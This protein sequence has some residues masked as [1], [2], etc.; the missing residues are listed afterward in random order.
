MRKVLL[1]WVLVLVFSGPGLADDLP[2][3]V[4]KSC[5]KENDVWLFSGSVH[6]ISILNIGVPLA[7][8]NALSNLASS[9]GISVNAAVGHKIDGS[10]TD[11]Y[12]EVINVSQGYI[13]DRVV[14]YGVRQKELHV[15]QYTDSSTGRQK[16]NVHA[17]LE[18]ADA[19]LKKAQADFCRRAVA[20][21]TPIMK[22]KGEADQKDAG[23]IRGLLRK[24]GL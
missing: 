4:H 6:G 7:R 13:L 23:I 20:K 3:W 16:F 10:E 24:V 1:A 14:A 9:I 11:G 12:T 17:L 21:P 5:Q 19:D 18:V 2:D 22:P 8:A 15:E